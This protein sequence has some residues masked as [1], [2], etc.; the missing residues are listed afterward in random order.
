MGV[1]VGDAFAVEPF[2]AAVTPEQIVGIVHLVAALAEHGTAVFFAD[3]LCSGLHP[4]GIGDGHAGQDLGLRNVGRDHLG[5]GQK[6]PCQDL[7]GAV[8]QQLG[9]GCGH[10]H[11]IDHDV[12][13]IVLAQLFG[14]GL[15]ERRRRHHADLDGI[16]V[17]IGEHRIQ[18][19]GQ[20]FGCGLKDSGHAGGV[21][22][23][24]SRDGAQS[25]HAVG[26]H[27][28]DVCL[29]ACAAAGIA[30]GNGQCCFHKENP[31]FSSQH[32]T[33][34]QHLQ[35]KPARPLFCRRKA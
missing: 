10:H 9:A 32:S 7:D 6:L 31:P 24:Q 17:D 3:A 13:C 22:G 16:R 25:K 5:H 21:L 14:N 27:G 30:S 1:G 29:N 18:L 23:R 12:L 19:L 35:G 11:G 2:A 15:N 33:V 34:R 20:K 26:G 28:L 4:G 8:L